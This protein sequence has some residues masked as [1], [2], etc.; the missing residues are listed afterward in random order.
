MYDRTYPNHQKNKR[1]GYYT[2]G[3]N[4]NARLILLLYTAEEKE[5]EK[6]IRNSMIRSI[7]AYIIN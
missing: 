2:L 7:L 3:I 1:T 6:N 5:H 4:R